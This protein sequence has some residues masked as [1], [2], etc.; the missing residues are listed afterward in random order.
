[1]FVLLLRKLNW[2][3]NKVSCI[4]G[5]AKEDD[6]SVISKVKVIQAEIKHVIRKRGFIF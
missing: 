4:Q 6:A 2:C 3:G 1:M 5:A